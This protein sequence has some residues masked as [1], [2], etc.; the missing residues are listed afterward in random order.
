MTPTLIG[1]V[2]V[3]VGLLLLLFGSRLAMLVYVMV[4][5]LM[6]GSA[7]VI[8]SAVGNVSIAPAV[9][10]ALFLAA[11]CIV[12][13]RSGTAALTR[14]LLD[15][16]WLILLVGY[17]FVGAY[18]LPFLFRRSILVVPLRPSAGPYTLVPLHFTAQHLTTSMYM[19]M[20]LLAAICAAIAVSRRGAGRTIARLASVITLLHAGIGWFALLFANTPL[21][22]IITFFRNGFYAQ[23]DQTFD[24]FSRMTGISPEPS[25]YAS[26]GYAWFVFVT[27]LWLRNIDRRWSGTAALVMFLTLLISTSS[28]AY[29]GLAAYSAA[30]LVRLLF[31]F[32]TI[33]IRKGL[34]ILVCLLTLAGCAIALIVGSEG[35]ANEVGKI[36]RLTTTDKLHSASGAA[37]GMWAMQGLHA[38]FNSGGLGIGVGSF[39]SSSIV[40]AIL[41][42]SGVI[43]IVALVCYVAKVFRPFAAT[44]YTATGDIDRDTATAAAWT[45]LM[46]LVPAAVS[47]PSPD[48]GLLWGLFA[49]IALGLRS[50]AKRSEIS[51]NRQVMPGFAPNPTLLVPAGGRTAVTSMTHADARFAQQE[52]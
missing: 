35:I 4:C 34:A 47:A 27:E 20:T 9:T 38:F 50:V 48:P 39:R 19:M 43:G 7:V 31:F 32:G 12:P 18:T 16:G 29:V 33:P 14:S 3:L 36:L 37:R 6:N 40:T 22:A 21:N 45:V 51:D 42:S 46:V 30:V 26:F 1:A 41:G 52:Q 28:T 44:T 11:R 8:L 23:L 2:V 15:N 10:A 13:T 5:S 17:S 49:G 25:L 24:G